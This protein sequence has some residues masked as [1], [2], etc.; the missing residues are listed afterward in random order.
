MKR[1]GSSDPYTGK[2]NACNKLPLRVPKCK[3]Q[4]RCQRSFYE[5]IQEIKGGY[6]WG[7]K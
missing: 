2:K 4:Q 3:T 6:I 1:P 5:Y 7:L